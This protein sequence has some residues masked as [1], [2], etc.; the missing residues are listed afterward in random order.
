[1]S[2]YSTRIP[3][4]LDNKAT[5]LQFLPRDKGTGDQRNAWF[6]SLYR[7]FN[8]RLASALE[9]TSLGD[10]ES[11]TNVIRALR[12][13]SSVS[14][15]S[16]DRSNANIIG[17]SKKCRNKFCYLCNRAKSKKLSTRLIKAITEDLADYND[18]HFYFL[19]L[20]LKHDEHTRNYDYLSELKDYQS[21]L[22]RS[23][24]WLEIFGSD[25]GIIQAFEN[26]MVKGMH[27]HSH[28]MIF[29][30][31]LVIP[32]K[33]AQQKIRDKWLKLTKDSMVIRFD[34]IGKG[35]EDLDSEKMRKSVMELFKYSTKMSFKKRDSIYANERLA[36]W[37]LSSKSKN[38]TNARGLFRGLQ[39]TGHKSRLDEKMEPKVLDVSIKHYF[40][41]TSKIRFNHS[42]RKEYT[43]ETRRK[44][45]DDVFIQSI[46]DNWDCS[47]MVEDVQHLLNFGIDESDCMDLVDHGLIEAQELASQTVYEAPS[48]VSNV[49]QMRIFESSSGTYSGE[50]QKRF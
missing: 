48:V 42:T 31:R 30:P 10:E 8:L 37:V 38:F 27:I 15:V 39:L 40:E 1:M 2:S 14:L 29:A 25:H 28:N 9:S 44:V 36:E 22:F 47:A 19:T 26:S 7:Y 16:V 49:V 32:A 21:K 24:I 50:T 46:R 17:T 4:V 11:I 18:H 13:C 12:W 45:L 33:L 6:T 34:L 35:I 41:K 43:A 20:T 23:K 5:F 3:S